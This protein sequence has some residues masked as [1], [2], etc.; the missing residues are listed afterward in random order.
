MHHWANLILLASLIL[1]TT[2]RSASPSPKAPPKKQVFIVFGGFLMLA[3]ALAIYVRGRHKKIYVEFE[4]YESDRNI[5]DIDLN[6][7]KRPSFPSSE[8]LPTIQE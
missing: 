4:C 2:A 7:M 1:A 8:E 6:F 5:G 3:V